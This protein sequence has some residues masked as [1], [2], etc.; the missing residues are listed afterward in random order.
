M[1]PML[2]EL[3]AFGPFAHRQA[4]DF[5]ELGTKTFF[6]IHGPTGAGKTSILDG[7]CFAL[8]GDS[9]GGE[10]DGRQMRSH[11]ADS[12][13]LT[14]VSF[15][16]ALGALTYRVR[17]VPE[18]MRKA[19]RGGGETK[20]LQIAE[21]CRLDAI[22]GVEVK[23]PLAS[24]WSKVTEAVVD[25]L[26]FE[27]E[28]F[29]QVIMLPQGKFFE[30]L[31][32]SSQ[33][34]EKI[35]QTLFGT[36]LYKRIE[37]QLKLAA[38]E[39]SRQA[40]RVRTQRQTLLDQAR[41]D[42]EAA[43]DSRQ[44]QQTEEL[45]QR[46]G[47]EQSSAAAALA[48]EGMLAAARR[49]ADQF[50]EL[51]KATGLLQSLR[52]QE[53]GWA[54]KRTQL[55]DARRAALIEPYV[56]AVAE[57]DR[58]S[59]EA[60]T[61]VKTLAEQLATAS[62]AHES[63]DVAL[64]RERQR[65][66]EI[67]QAMALI[68]RLDA[69]GE[70]VAA[71]ATARADHATAMAEAGK[72][73]TA[74]NAAQQNHKAVSQALQGHSNRIQELRIQAAEI[75]GLRSRHTQLAAQLIHATTLTGRVA[76]Q[77]Q[78]IR[79]VEEERSRLRTTEASCVEAR[80]QLD[81]VRQDWVAGQAARLAHELVDG[82]PCPVCGGSEHPVPAKASGAL[83][84][85]QT[86]KAA[87]SVVSKSEGEQREAA[88]K[89]ATA[90]QAVG[91]LDARIA[92]LRTALGE[93]P[94]SVDALKTQAEAAR[95]AL[96]QAETA[97]RVLK[98]LEASLAA[99][100]LAVSEAEAAVKLTDSA[101]QGAQARL[102]QMNGLLAERVAGI[103][104]ELSEPA[105]LSLART[106]AIQVRDTLRQSVEAATQTATR[107]SHQLIEVKTRLE[108]S[109][110]ASKTLA[111]QRAEHGAS[112]DARLAAAGFVNIDTYKRAYLETS[113][114]VA[115]ENGI[116]AFSL[117][118]AA[119][120]ERQ[121][122][123]AEATRDIARPDLPGLTAQ[124]ESAKA[125]LLAASNAVRDAL[126]ALA[127]TATFVESLTRLSGEYQSIEGRYTVLKQVSDVAGGANAQRMSF[128]RYVLATLLE[129]VL[130]ATT[131]RLQVM[132]R[133]RYEMRRKLQ[134]SDQ[135]AAAGLDLEVFDQYTGT[136]RAVSTLSGGESFLASLALALGLSD[137]VQAYAGGIR[138]DAI[139]VDE[140][141]GTLDPESLDFAVRALQDLQQAGR[142]VGIIS[143]VAELKEWI[144][145]R[146][147]V[148]AA[149]S[150]S[151]AEFRL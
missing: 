83:V 106:A 19:R 82:Q 137:V 141:F 112:L 30:F 64:V 125:A 80:R 34:R 150:G 9:S 101:A 37:D 79:R 54:T 74:L 17:R 96:T 67:E 129:E 104:A 62:K 13:T 149:Q 14:E 65:A 3:Q 73:T 71:L 72:A 21:L 123:A 33:D 85:D 25:L 110:S 46:R 99:A 16:F 40:D 20:Q 127:A 139:F 35:L 31:K 88:Q 113:A 29:R 84:L 124:H 136:T 94:A 148:T 93:M 138:L 89:L 61:R 48:A 63:A 121:S 18:Q 26:G 86:L 108:A 122:R 6:L 36:E 107:A 97:S 4:I 23:R 151:V 5:R 8:F 57:L 7:I 119:A 10:R 42:N 103:P 70:K 126:A 130:V 146:L 76:E 105:A 44:Q 134:A 118:L 51:D 11:H 38:N 145:A 147:E 133:G 128:Q 15:S 81:R 60:S 47:A 49:S 22:E 92:E 69:L 95:T 75:N 12:D 111:T 90:Q 87:E 68:A 114:A 1:K 142:M 50:Q 102:Q 135:R 116:D 132:S 140:G 109:E 41:A 98:E 55:A 52:G 2:L 43:L 32:S 45:T 58:Q 53:V 143:H 115:L 144:D 66:P 59:G 117:S 56:A 27:S 39:L 24:G 77:S 131:L 100:Q 28:Q 91:V 120:A 78:A